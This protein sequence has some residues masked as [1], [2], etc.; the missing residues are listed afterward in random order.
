VKRL[1]LPEKFLQ[2]II[3]KIS[4]TILRQY[5]HRLFSVKFL[6]I[7]DVLINAVSRQGLY[8]SLL[9]LFLQFQTTDIDPSAVFLGEYEVEDRVAV[10]NDI[11]LQDYSLWEAEVVEGVVLDA[12][13]FIFH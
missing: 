3:E 11:L 2:Q 9:Q 13:A 8:D 1:V 10:S 4:A 12:G 6:M 7:M 5:A